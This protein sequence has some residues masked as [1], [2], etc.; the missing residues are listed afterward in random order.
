MG[1]LASQ[2]AVIPGVADLAYVGINPGGSPLGRKS[3]LQNLVPGAFLTAQ[4]TNEVK[5]WPPVVNTGDLDALKLWWRKVGTPTLAPSVV[6]VSGEGITETYKLAIKVTTDAGSEGMSQVWTYAD[7]PRL[8]SGRVM[9]ALVA[10]W[11][12]GGV[13]VTAKLVNSDAS[14]TDAAA[15]T[16][17]AWTLVEIPAHALAGTTCTLQITASG[18]GTFY[19]VPL[20]ANIGTRAFALPPRPLRFVTTLGTLVNGV[21][22]NGAD[23]TDVDATASS[24]PLA[25]ILYLMYQYRHGGGPNRT[26]WIRRNGTVNNWTVI[27][28]YATNIHMRQPIVIACDDEQVF[29]YKTWG[30]APESET[31]YIWIYGYWEWA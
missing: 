7:E 16:A 6:A 3:V 26:C 2:P 31:A 14:H 30:S 10:I 11:C 20:G 24:S 17:A 9:S 1:N 15:V 25:A 23:Y 22:P 19:V 13:S 12:V 5:G 8:K 18:A 29:E 27:Y 28:E 4:L 21:D